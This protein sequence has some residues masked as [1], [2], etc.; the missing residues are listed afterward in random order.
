M[1]HDG[2]LG[3]SGSVAGQTGSSK[4][5]RCL[6]LFVIVVI[7]ALS[8][9]L[10]AT[11]SRWTSCEE[12]LMALRVDMKKL[13]AMKSIDDKHLE[14]LKMRM[15]QLENAVRRKSSEVNDVVRDR[16]NMRQQLEDSS[17]KLEVVQKELDSSKQ[18]VV[19]RIEFFN[20]EEM[21]YKNNIQ[22]VSVELDKCHK[23]LVNIKA[24]SVQSNKSLPSEPL[25]ERMQGGFPDQRGLQIISKPSLHSS[26]PVGGQEN[27]KTSGNEA[28]GDE[29]TLKKSDDQ[30]QLPVTINVK[31]RS[32]LNQ[33]VAGESLPKQ[34]GEPSSQSKDPTSNAISVPE[35]NINNRMNNS[36]TPKGNSSLVGNAS[37]SL[38]G[39][40]SD[41][42]DATVLDQERPGKGND[43]STGNTSVSQPGNA[44]VAKN[45]TAAHDGSH[46]FLLKESLSG[47][48]GMLNAVP[49]SKSAGV[50]LPGS[51]LESRN[52]NPLGAQQKMLFGRPGLMQNERE[53][54]RGNLLR[55][56]KDNKPHPNSVVVEKDEA[57]KEE[58][59]YEKQK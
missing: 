59:G 21:N 25:Q 49:G 24:G 8:H 52:S 29:E 19:D 40:G 30:I 10:W 46:D 33:T 31:S 36:L 57:N 55:D 48:D 7:V 13:R 12:Q 9:Q 32:P 42:G 5:W 51:A 50:G 39:N 14:S 28:E 1:A 3:K 37:S 15:S 17:R 47:K 54:I 26:V 20:K 58:N 2:L 56:Q 53:L 23:T 44:A 4:V 6:M 16:E 11:T 38:Q 22:T 43:S 34:A 45:D 41:Q 18:A 27:D 35:K